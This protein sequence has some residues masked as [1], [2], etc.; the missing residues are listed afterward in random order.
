MRPGFV[1]AAY[2]DGAVC[3]PSSPTG[4]ISRPKGSASPCSPVSCRASHSPAARSARCARLRKSNEELG[5]A[6]ATIRQLAT[7]DTLTGLPNRALFTESLNRALARA[8]RHGWPVALL[9]MDLDR[10]KNL[11]DTLGHQLGDEAL[12]E[13]ARRLDSCIRESDVSGLGGDEFVLLVEE[14]EGPT[15]LIETAE[16]IPAAITSRPRSA[17]KRSICR[18]RRICTYPADARD[19]GALL[20]RGYRALPSEGAGPEPLPFLFTAQQCAHRRVPARW[21]A[22]RS[23]AMS[24]AALPAE[25]R[26]RVGAHRRCRGAARWQ[27]PELGL[28]GRTGLF[29]SPR[30][31]A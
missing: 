28:C 29:R 5:S 10:F 26:H 19:A 23:S 27:H 3:S 24:P 25:D 13:A 1:L 9:F 11:N 8:D 20:Q 18:C 7:H 6:L 2:S 4:S 15:V 30:R 14:Y 31:R 17:D 22:T 16:R 12:K 21:P